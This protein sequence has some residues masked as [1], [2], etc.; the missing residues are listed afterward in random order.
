VTIRKI[1][2][3]VA[4]AIAIVIVAKILRSDHLVLRAVGT[5]TIFAIATALEIIPKRG[6]S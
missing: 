6:S 4:L 5:L 1:S 3:A 2:E